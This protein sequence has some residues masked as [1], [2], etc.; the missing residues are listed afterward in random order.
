MISALGCGAALTVTCAFA[1]QVPGAQTE[2]PARKPALPAKPAP[3]DLVRVAPSADAG[4]PV[5]TDSGVSI[6]VAQFRFSGNASQPEQLLAPLLTRYVG[7]SLT[8]AQLNEAA[9]VIKR[10]YRAKGWFLA[11]AYIPAQQP[12]NGIV[13]IAVLE[14]RIDRLTVN[15]APDAPISADYANRLVAAH[16]QSG[17]TITETGLEAPLLLLR[18]LPRVDAK[19]VINPGSVPGTA[20]IAINLVKDPDVR[21]IS[22]RVDLDNYGSKVTGSTRLGAEVNLNNPYG[23]GDSLSLRGFVAS[24]SGNAFGRAGYNLPVG[25]GG[26]RVGVSLARLDY[27]LG[28]LFA[29]LK[30]NGVANVLSANIDY[31]LRRGRNS[32]LYTQLMLER[33]NLED[34]TTSPFSSDK[35]A[36][37]SARFQLS[38][39][40]RDDFAGVTVFN[41]SLAAGK[42]HDDDPVRV[43]NDALGLQ[44]EGNF[45]KLLFSVQ[46]L[47]QLLPGLHGMFSASGQYTNKNLTSAEKF[48][49]GGDSTVRGFPVG[50]LVGDQGATATAELRWTPAALKFDRLDLA[51]VA[52]Y[53]IGR[54]TRN[55]DNSRDLNPINTSTISGYGVGFNIA[56]G[57]SFLFKLSVAWP[58]KGLEQ[59]DVA[60]GTRINEPKSGARAWA[61]ASYAF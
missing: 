16:L 40:A 54:V 36:L 53:D 15:V 45:A 60:S 46:R 38:G 31:P 7:K 10:H 24:Q 12:A 39:D 11:Q 44:T 26:A 41:V 4:A 56:Y 9:D 21:V 37:T 8:L 33:K 57:Y 27:V 59:F 3:A 2:E 35:H 18:D 55:H 13:E 52:F 28:N 1:D 20:S 49:I 17:Q 61:L 23:L 6:A 5:M 47:Q 32:N 51:G 29:V 30:P 25:A 48:S 43:A 50:T 22:G 34:R 42:L 19:S 14:G 58:V